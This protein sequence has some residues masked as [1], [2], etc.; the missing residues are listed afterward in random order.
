MDLSMAAYLIAPI[1]LWMIARVWINSHIMDRLLSGY[2]LILSILISIVFILDA[3]LYPYWGFRLDATPLFYFTSSPTAAMASMAWWVELILLLATIILSWGVFKLMR[4]VWSLIFKNQVPKNRIATTIV[5]VLL[6][7]L[8]IIPIRGGVTV[9]TMSPGRSYFSDDMRLNHASVNPMFSLMYS[10]FH[11]DDTANQMHFFD[12]ETA[13]KLYA[14]INIYGSSDS[15]P[16]VSLNKEHPNVYIIILESFSAHLMP[17]LGGDSIAMQLDSIAANGLLFTDAYAGSFRT[18]RALTTVLS[19]YPAQPSTSLLRYV[20]KFGNLPAISATMRNKGY[21]T[22]YYYGGDIN[23]TNLNAYLV[24]TGYEYIIKD[25]DFPISQRL[26]K[27]GVH[28]EYVFERA[29]EDVSNDNGNK[30]MLRV[31]QTSSSHEPFEVP[32]A[33]FTDNRKNAFAYTDLC[34]G[35][36]IRALKS[37]GEWDNSL[38]AIIPDHWGAYPRELTDEQA[39]HHVPMIFTG[40]LMGTPVEISSPSSQHDLAATLLGLLNMSHNDF[41]FSHDLL[42][43]SPG[44]AVFSEPGWIAIKTDKGLTVVQTDTGELIKGNEHDGDLVKAYYQILYK[45]LSNR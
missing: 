10:L 32:Y 33:A 12:D 31:I 15:I 22:S 1:V 9:S 7:G 8:L 18:D 34:V 43:F 3:T 35:S 17:R 16:S 30:P 36:F 38:I 39:R 19:G 29:L 26:S 14:E 21:T 23:F 13:Q 41:N 44:Y 5:L 27:W 40:A 24:A 25:S 11:R 20:D 37:S 42:S 6:A 4:K 45:D 28:D 2:M